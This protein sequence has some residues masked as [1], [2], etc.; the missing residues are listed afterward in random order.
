MVK[1][2]PEGEE[3][4]GVVETDEFPRE[5]QG[6]DGTGF[7]R[8]V[9][10]FVRFYCCVTL[11]RLQSVQKESGDHPDSYIKGLKSSSSEGKTAGS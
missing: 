9:R 8:N 1:V 10:F 2:R 3:N 6:H 5:N 4:F 11:R 7:L